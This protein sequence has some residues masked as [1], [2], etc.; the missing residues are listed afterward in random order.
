MERTGARSA[1]ALA[2][3]LVLR[4]EEPCRAPGKAVYDVL[5]DPRT[6][7]TWPGER[8]RK[9]TRLLSIKAPQGP[10]AVGT[11]FRTTGADARGSFSDRSVVTEATAGKTIE[12]VTEARRTTR[13]GRVIDWTNVHRYELTSE[14][15]GCRIA[16]TIRV[17]RINKLVGMLVAFRIPGL[18]VLGLRAS[19]GVARRGLRRL[20]RMAQEG[21]RT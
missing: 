11:E 3:A 21:W 2:R 1:N 9:R 10:V 8:H 5:A 12:F 17:A 13:K 18:R 6:H 19:A 7:L 15:N 20:T 14:A 16:Y 4:V